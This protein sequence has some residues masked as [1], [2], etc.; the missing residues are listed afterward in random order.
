MTDGNDSNRTRRRRA[1]RTA[2]ILAGVVFAIYIGFI[3]RGML[4]AG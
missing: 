1:I 2:L 4:N 3:L